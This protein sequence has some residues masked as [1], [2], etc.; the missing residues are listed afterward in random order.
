MTMHARTAA[1]ATGVP[2][3]HPNG[4]L[5]LKRAA[6]AKFPH[7]IFSPLYAFHIFDK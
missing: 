3:I 5:D 2:L 7:G 6:A 1:T 4:G